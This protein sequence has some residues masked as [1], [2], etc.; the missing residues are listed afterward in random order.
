MFST[1]TRAVPKQNKDHWPFSHN[2]NPNADPHAAPTNET[3][4]NT[5][6]KRFL[7]SGKMA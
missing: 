2:H 5:V 3:D 4:I 1:I 6:F 7:A